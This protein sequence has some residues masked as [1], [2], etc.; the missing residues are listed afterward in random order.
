VRQAVRF[1]PELPQRMHDPDQP[2]DPDAFLLQQLAHARRRDDG[3]LS[4]GLVTAELLERHVAAIDQRIRWKTHGWRA[5]EDDRAEIANGVLLRLAQTLERKTAF[6]T[7]FRYVVAANVDWEVTDVVR[8]R[9]RHSAE[10]PRD[11][12]DLPEVGGERGRKRG[13]EGGATDALPDVAR[14]GPDPEALAA[15]AR[16]FADRIGELAPRDRRI[17]TERF[18][19]GTPIEE[20]ADMLDM[21]RGAV[22]TATH[23]ALKRLYPAGDERPGAPPSDGKAA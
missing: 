5:S 2:P 19:V 15:Q 6:T 21:S 9:V 11:V 18:F 8:R 7:A 4:A 17:L 16:D 13:G 20:I 10:A 3:G 23:R 14:S 1:V 12:D 22:D